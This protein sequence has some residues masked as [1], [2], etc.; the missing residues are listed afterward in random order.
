MIIPID[1]DKNSYKTHH[2]FTL[3]IQKKLEEKEHTSTL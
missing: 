3:K 2:P 1:A